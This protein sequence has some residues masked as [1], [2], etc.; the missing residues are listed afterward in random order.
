MA[1]CLKNAFD[2]YRLEGK[3]INEAY[4]LAKIDY[5]EA[6]R[7]KET[8]PA[9]EKPTN[10]GFK[11][12]VRREQRIREPIIREQAEAARTHMIE[13]T[14]QSQKKAMAIAAYD[15]VTGDIQ[16][17]FAGPI[18]DRIA[19]VR[20]ERAKSIGGIG[21]KGLTAGLPHENTVGVCAEFRSANGLLLRHSRIEN[22]RFTD[23]IRPRT[24]KVISTCPNCEAMFPEAFGGA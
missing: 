23:A 15:V 1:K 4:E 12:Y 5:E 18:P 14:P 7:R 9:P 20:Q 8:I 11:E 3:D 22:I 13:T 10:D 16:P 6:Q 24:G 17:E 21:S 19:T 2:K